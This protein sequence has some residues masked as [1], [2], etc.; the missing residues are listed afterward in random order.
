MQSTGTAPL[1]S[2]ARERQWSLAA[3]I[4]SVTVFGLSIGQGSPLMS[5]LLESRGS[6]ATLNGL[7]AGASF[8]GVIVGPLL[9]P[10][11][12]RLLGVRNFLLLCFGAD[13]A[14]FMAMKPFHSVADWFALRLLLGLIGSSIFTSSEAWINQLAGDVGRGRILGIYA[15]ALAAGFGIGPLVLSLTGIQGWPP[16]LANAAIT[17]LAA[18]PLL[19]VGETSRS[20]GRERGASPLTM[21]RRAPLIL[22]AV[23]IFAMYEAAMMTLLPIWGVRIGLNDRLAAATLSAVFFGSI[24]L[25]VLIGWLSDRFSRIATLRL[26]GAVGLL[27]A[28]ALASVDA[29]LPMLLGL[30]FVWGGIASGIYPVA[31]SMAGDRFRGTE[32]V[33]V[34]AAMIIAYGLGALVGPPLGGVAMDVWNARGLFWLFA[35][36]FAG[37][38]LAT[39]F[40]AGRRPPPDSA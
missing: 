23:T 9:A 18:L 17:A 20:F 25:Q 35:L 12:V 2:A 24:V 39:R 1:P 22:G 10:I 36:L 4:A 31:L 5:L 34:N 21:F 28:L 38:L 40:T 13:I 15:A 16:F 29:S 7:N 19:G 6:D 14:L 37:L 27:G 8:A 32:L 11:C 3:A 26:C 30:L 33:T